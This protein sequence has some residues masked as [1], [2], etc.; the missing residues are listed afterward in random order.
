MSDQ[1]YLKHNYDVTVKDD[2]G[3]TVYSGQVGKNKTVTLSGLLAGNYLI[4]ATANNKPTITQSFSVPTQAGAIVF[5][6]M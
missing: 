1:E 5:T 2:A 4:T 3:A 6:I